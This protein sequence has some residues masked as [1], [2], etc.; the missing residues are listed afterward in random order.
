MRHETRKLAG[1]IVVVLTAV[2][3]QRRTRRKRRG[4]RQD[5]VAYFLVQSENPGADQL[6]LKATSADVQHR[7]RH[8]SVKVTQ[9]YKNE[10]R[11]PSR[12]S[13]FSP[14]P[15]APPSTP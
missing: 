6:P 5:A 8:A 13:T 4:E 7:R 15:S 10:G 2:I 14:A 3:F 9:V 12:R 11:S 1:A